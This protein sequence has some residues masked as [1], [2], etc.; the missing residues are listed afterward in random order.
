[1][2]RRPLSA[3]ALAAMTT[4]ALAAQS[5]RAGTFA[6]DDFESYTV[7][8]QLES[9][10]NGAA[11]T[12]LNG[13]SGWGANA[14]NSDDATKSQATIA[15]ASL[16]YANGSINVNGGSKALKITGGVL[17][18]TNQAL[19]LL[20]TAQTGQTF[21]FGFLYQASAD[22]LS[23]EDFLQ[24]GVSD[25]SN[26]EPKVSVGTGGAVANQ[27]PIQWFVRD[28]NGTAN[29]SFG[30]PATAVTPDVHLVVAKVS[31]TGSGTYNRIDL[32]LDPTSLA[33]PGTSTIGLT[34]AATAPATLDRFVIR[35]F[36]GDAADQYLLDNLNFSDTFAGAI[37]V[38]EPATLG[39]ASL[40]ALTLL[41]R[42]RRHPRH[43]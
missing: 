7:G 36:R 14:Y 43:G 15:A 2:H 23:Q 35:Y 16:T 37:A 40:G 17:D 8:A 24:I 41:A 19:R 10:A 22:T 3:I 12:G 25:T 18:S 21:Y 5:A 39:L 4:V 13:G 38:P 42:R 31:Q 33:E 32:Y 34:A 1:M 30:T 29:N 28:P 26:A 27:T 20:P 11:G 6:N 9:G